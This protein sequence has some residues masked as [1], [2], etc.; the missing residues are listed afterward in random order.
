[1]NYYVDLF[2]C[3]NQVVQWCRVNLSH[4]CNQQSKDVRRHELCFQNSVSQL[5]RTLICTSSNIL[6]TCTCKLFML[7]KFFW[8]IGI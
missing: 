7:G 8:H 2:L 3:A 5:G 4:D 6:L 1:M